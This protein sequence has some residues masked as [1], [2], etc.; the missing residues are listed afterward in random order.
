MTKLNVLTLIRIQNVRGPN[1]PREGYWCDI[2]AVY[3]WA[4]V[5]H[6]FI[7]GF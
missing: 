6:S 1:G 7:Q 4:L 3:N 5:G 2:E